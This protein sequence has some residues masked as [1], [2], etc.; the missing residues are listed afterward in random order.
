MFD[1][2]KYEFQIEGVNCS[3][4]TG[5][6]ARKSQSAVF[7]KM[8]DTSI[9][10]TVNVGEAKTDADFFP[11]SVEYMEKMYAAGKISGSRFVKRERFPTDDAILKARMI[12]RTVRSRFPKGYRNE[13][14]IIVK[15]LSYDPMYDPLILGINAVSAALL[16]SPAP[17]DE[18]VSGVRVGYVDGQFTAF[19]SNTD[20]DDLGTST[21]NLVVG[22][23][24]ET[25]TNID[26]NA[27]ELPEDTMIDAMKHGLELMKPWIE[28]QNKF[29]EMVGEVKKAEYESFD[30]PEALVEKAMAV[31]GKEIDALLADR[32]YDKGGP[33]ELMERMFEE[34]SGEYS[35]RQVTETYFELAKKLTRKVVL[36]TGKRV[37]GRALDE[38]RPLDTQ[39]GLLPRTHGTGLFSRG[40]TQVLTV[41]TLGSS[42]SQMIVDDMTGEDSRRYMHYY[43]E[44]PYVFGEAGRV[45][46]MP[47]RREVGHGALAEKALFPVLPSMEEFPYTIILMSEIMS[48]EGSSSMGSTCGS[49]LALMDAGV[50]IKKP[51]AGVAV[52]VMFD[53][54]T[55]EKF[56]TLVDIQGVEDFYGYMDFKVTG[57]VDGVTAVQMD[58]KAKG[59]PIEVF[60]KAIAD[61]K[62]ARLKILDQ[63]NSAIS[64]PR[65]QLSEF[66]PK[67]EVVK[68]PVAKIGEL[69]GPGG[70][71]IKKIGEDTGAEIDIEEDGTVNIFAMDAESLA[72]A[73]AAV[74][75][76]AFVPEV[77][78]TYMGLVEKLA[79][80]GAF[81]ELV[82]GVTGL[83]HV[84]EMSDKYVRDAGDFVKEGEQVEVLVLGVEDNGKIKLTMKGLES[85][86][87]RG[88]ADDGSGDSGSDRDG[89]GGDRGGRGGYG[90]SRG[91]SDRRGGRGR[92]GYGDRDG[93]R[94]DYNRY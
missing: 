86:K 16:I 75:P 30:L 2:K 29:V 33:K 83:V 38:I 46:Y 5:L 59:L 82:P 56:V 43:V 51:V 89:R 22:G 81:V 36:E 64:A 53:E 21:L 88:P 23:D 27:Y 72:K 94:R 91:G 92:G 14:S 1:E 68:I 54:E 49:T 6:L 8:G 80:F 10:A 31:Y 42:R 48:E 35:K 41:A 32:A 20:R 67:V 87:D 61:S 85:N 34:F 17:I 9:L 40:M 55:P 7:A 79:D 57:T 13:V 11:M 47:G 90:G 19:N 58:T 60:E 93:G 52:G 66:A 39:V 78:K 70:K 3:F 50:P 71:N 28:A 44:A 74:E 4:S 37:D 73:K 12:D 77:G 45:N 69:I 15:V 84:S 18:P 62:A 76:F 25:F 65:E 24:G 26:S 63:I